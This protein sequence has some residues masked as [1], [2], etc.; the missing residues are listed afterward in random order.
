VKAEF[1]DSRPAE[2]HWLADLERSSAGNE[3][4][5][6]DKLDRRVEIGRSQ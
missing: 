2:I 5:P 1:A 4:M 3:R 6:R